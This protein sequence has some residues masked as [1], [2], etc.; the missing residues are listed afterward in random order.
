MLALD[1]MILQCSKAFVGSLLVR[2]RQISL[3]LAAVAV[4]APRYSNPPVSRP[5]IVPL[6]SF[7]PTISTVFPNA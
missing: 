2:I 4:R 3:A 5:C 1:A 6:E 7:I